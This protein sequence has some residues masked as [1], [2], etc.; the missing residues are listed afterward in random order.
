M[1]TLLLMAAVLGTT[2]CASYDQKIM[3][4]WMGASESQLTQVWGYPVSNDD[5]VIVDENTKVYTYRYNTNDAWS[6]APTTCRISFTLKNSVVSR[7]EYNGASCPRYTR[8]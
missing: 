7:W 1:R 2:S 3:A 4:P 6:G 8:P 5:R